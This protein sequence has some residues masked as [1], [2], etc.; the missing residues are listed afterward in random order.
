[1][2]D[3]PRARE[4]LA[5]S[6]ALMAKAA[7][8]ATEAE[9]LMYKGQM[10]KR[11]EEPERERDH[12]EAHPDVEGSKRMMSYLRATVAKDDTFRDWV[13]DVSGDLEI[14]GHLS[15]SQYE[16]AKRSVVRGKAAEAR[17]ARNHA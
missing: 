14:Y 5:E 1:M 7:T 10:S 11:N 16:A 4:L 6:V 13:E 15:L 2:S 3:I 9:S 12:P 17:R 8:K